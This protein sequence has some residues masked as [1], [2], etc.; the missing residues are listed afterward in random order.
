MLLT[1]STPS[2]CSSALTTGPNWCSSAESAQKASRDAL[3]MA[4]H[5]ADADEYLVVVN[6]LVDVPVCHNLV[7][8]QCSFDGLSTSSC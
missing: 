2:S 5:P 8:M 4:Q 1:L 6:Q 7:V 3:P